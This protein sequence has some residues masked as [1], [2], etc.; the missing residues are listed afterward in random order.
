MFARVVCLTAILFAAA[1]PAAAADVSS[2]SITAGV[3]GLVKAG[4]WVPVQV[5]IALADDAVEPELVVSWGTAT[6]RR[7]VA[8]GGEAGR[9]LDIYIR[10]DEVAGAITAQ[11]RSHGRVLAQAEAPVR[12]LPQAE[13]IVACVDE[14]RDAACTANVSADQL[15]TSLRGYETIDRI[16]FDGDTP[17]LGADQR[18]A[19]GAWHALQR[20]NEGGDLGL[21]AQPARPTLPRGLPAPLLRSVAAIVITYAGVLL[22]IGLA[23]PLPWRGARRGVLVFTAVVGA[24]S[25]TVLAFGAGLPKR[26]VVVHHSSLVEQ[27][28]DSAISLISFRAIAEFPAAGRYELRWPLADAMLEPASAG[29]GT[30]HAFEAGGHPIL[31]GRRGLGARQAFRGEATAAVHILAVRTDGRMVT[32]SNDSTFDLTGCRFGTGYEAT[33]TP[34]LDGGLPAGASVTATQTGQPSGPLLSCTFDGIVVPF[35]EPTSAVLSTG[36]TTIAVYQ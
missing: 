6:V 34:T 14:A 36:S 7:L 19:L 3:G 4:R 31:S 30:E 15:P 10:T 29:A 28:P 32:V 8:A 26:P 2:L 27:L 24:G 13:P 35:E 17:A 20:L 16:I 21:V 12:S 18:A 9:R 25:A 5:S 23:R 33:S 1:A 22:V 11:L